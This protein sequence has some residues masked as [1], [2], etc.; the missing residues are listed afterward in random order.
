M[1]KEERR[2][3]SLKKDITFLFSMILKKINFW[4]FFFLK[5]KGKNNF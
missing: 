1:C 2:C 5:R 3:Q 4:Y